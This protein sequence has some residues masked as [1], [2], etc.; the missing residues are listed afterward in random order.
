MGSTTRAGLASNA[1]VTLRRH[2]LALACAAA[3]L[4]ASG[5]AQA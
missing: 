4:M 5:F 3:C 2:P 1:R